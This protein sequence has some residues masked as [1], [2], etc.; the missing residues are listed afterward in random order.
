MRPVQIVRDQ[1]NE[2]DSADNFGGAYFSTD[3]LPIQTSDLYVFYRDKKDNQPDLSPDEHRS[4]R[5]A[6]GTVRP[7]G[8]LPLA[9]ASNQIRRNWVHG[10]T[11]G[12]SFMKM[13]IFGRLIATPSD[14]I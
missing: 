7:R 3:W 4:T 2:S 1:F 9:P 8:S 11:A 6:V 5:R 12:N 13:A 10:I 14:L